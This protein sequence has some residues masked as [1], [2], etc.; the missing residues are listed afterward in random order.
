MHLVGLYTYSGNVSNY[1]ITQYLL[2]KHFLLKSA[3]L[4]AETH[5]GFI[6]HLLFNRH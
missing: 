1:M 2:V 4:L 6:A 5:S 3:I